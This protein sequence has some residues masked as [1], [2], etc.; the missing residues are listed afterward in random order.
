MNTRTIA[1]W[2]VV[3][4]VIALGVYLIV[5]NP[6]SSSASANQQASSTAQTAT[7]TNQV[8]A[9]DVTVGTGAEAA[10]GSWVSVLYVGALADGTVFDSSQAHGNQPL[11]FQLGAQGL[12]PGFQIGVNTMKVGGERKMAIPPSLGYGAVDVHQDPNDP[13]SKIVIPANSTL[14][15][16][17]K[18]VKVEPGTTTPAK[19]Q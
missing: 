17:V 1:I 8:Q 13:K 3:I 7:S 2:V 4:L 15:F 19:T 14:V 5:K 10:P 9:Q 16:D 12:I 18:L 6:F 11:R